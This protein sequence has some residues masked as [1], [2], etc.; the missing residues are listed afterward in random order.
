MHYY[1]FD[2]FAD[3]QDERVL[4]CMLGMKETTQQV[5]VALVACRSK[6]F[7]QW[8]PSAADLGLGLDY[9][10]SSGEEPGSQQM[11]EIQIPEM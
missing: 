1:V 10:R 7:H 9:V 3:V 5:V 8:T 2:C 6:L 4:R 11:E